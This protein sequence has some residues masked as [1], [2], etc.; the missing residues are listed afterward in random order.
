MPAII[1]VLYE[2]PEWFKPL[3]AE[4]ERQRLRFE[5]VLAHEASFD[6]ASRKEPY[7]LVVNRV[8]PSS[9]L[10]GHTA[11][12]FFASEYLAHLEAFGVPVVNGLAA[13]SLERS[14]AGQIA[15]YERLG[16]PYPRSIVV[17]H[18]GQVEAAAGQL[19]YPVMVKP[20]I[21][22]SG[23]L[24]QRF[25]SPEELRDAVARARVDLGIDHVGI[26]Q[27]YHPPIDG[28]IVRVEA[29]DGEFLYA[30]RIQSDPD[31][32][33]NLC[34]ADIC[35]VEDAPGSG[36]GGNRFDFCAATD[37]GKRALR[38]EAYKTP[39]EVIDDVLAINRAGQLDIGGVEYL[40]SSRDGQRYFY[41]I[42]AL[43]NF[44][45]DAPALVGFDPFVRFVDYLEDRL[46]EAVDQ[47]GRQSSIM[48]R[49]RPARASVAARS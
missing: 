41:D 37:P 17:N 2:H 5:G 13:W 26:V 40:E 23:A 31:Q 8:S 10:R 4:M 39:Q 24:M 30:I 42:N 36:G 44:V 21:G 18:A 7:A 29:L 16:L 38:I 25:A 15:L 32:G 27:E 1:A 49:R 12:I 22:G 19:E 3:F 47:S 46:A 6:P 20:N 33:F 48:A 28:S 11:A 45:T 35:Q 14:K 9:Y 34:P 43:S